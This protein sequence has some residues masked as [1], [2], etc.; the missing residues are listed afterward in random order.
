MEIRII[1]YGAGNLR[2]IENA[3]KKIGV[4][5]SIV[6]TP[7]GLGDASHIIL[8]GVGAFGDAMK[9]L[10][11]FKGPLKEKI[12]EG[13]PF[14]GLCLGIQAILG[15]SDESKGVEGLEFLA[16]TCKR[17]PDNVKVP[18][19][20]WNTVTKK[21]ETPLLKEIDSGS[22]FYFVHS[23]YPIPAN[24]DDIA[25]ETTYGDTTFASVI[26]KDNIHATQFH[27]E[28]SGETGLK[29]LENFTKLSK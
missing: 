7:G 23:Y 16:G 24:R 19:M 21:K 9:K 29:L 1:D 18:H 10:G 12:G 28:R 20:G 4:Q 11:E 6:D 27:P 2:S 8:P 14:L 17:F 15:E 25:C 22:F 26:S 5:A 13:T 3:L